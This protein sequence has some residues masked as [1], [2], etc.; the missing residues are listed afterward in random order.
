MKACFCQ[1]MTLVE[2]LLALALGAMLILGATGMLLAVS[3]SHAAQASHARIDDS[4]R[5]AMDAIARALRQSAY[6]NYVNYVSGDAGAVPLLPAAH[7]SASLAGLDAHSLSRNSEG[8]SN[9]LPDAMQGSDVL[10]VRFQGAGPADGGD[11][12]VLNC[13]GFGVGAPA[14]EGER[15]WSIFYV[16]IASDGEAELR[17]KYRGASSWGADALIRG[18]DSFQV[19]YGLDTDTPP[20]GVANQYVNATALAARDAAL[21]LAGESE[22]ERQ[23][24]LQRRTHWKRVTSVRL[25]LLL[26]GENDQGGKAG[27]TGPPQFDLFGAPYSETDGAADVGTRITVASLP[28]AQQGRVRKLV[29]TTVT[30]RNA[31]L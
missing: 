16:A 3:A 9:P 7:D 27:Q 24:D 13:A 14:S 19:L 29:Q 11:G 15:G 18:V 5:Y 1:G 8:I 31:A 6:V 28:P 26:H 2:L 17:C 20:D 22:P 21:G 23:R 30:L 12:S 25:A 10:A 4:G